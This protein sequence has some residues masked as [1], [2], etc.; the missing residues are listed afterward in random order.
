MME[1]YNTM[2][3]SDEEIYAIVVQLRKHPAIDKILKPVVSPEDFKSAFKFVPHKKASSFSGI[4]IHH[5][6]ACAEGSD[7]GLAD[8]QVEVHAAMMTV[9][10]DAGFCPRDSQVRHIENYSIAGSRSQSSLKDIIHQKHHAPRQ[11]S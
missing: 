2:P 1:I 10:F 3:L 11:K 8:I 4:G 5:Y 7:D 6:K 9:P